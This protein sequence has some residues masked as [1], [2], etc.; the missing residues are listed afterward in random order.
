[1]TCSRCIGAKRGTLQPMLHPRMPP[2]RRPGSPKAITLTP[3][4]MAPVWMPAAHRSH[5]KGKFLKPCSHLYIIPQRLHYNCHLQ[6]D[7]SFSKK[8]TQD[9]SFTREARQVCSAYPWKWQRL[10]EYLPMPLVWIGVL[11]C[12]RLWF[13][14]GFKTTDLSTAFFFAGSRNWAPHDQYS[15]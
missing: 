8:R 4:P 13:L 10:E 2:C 5:E 14:L 7:S 6:V 9:F 15:C 1:M 3:R 12:I 11:R